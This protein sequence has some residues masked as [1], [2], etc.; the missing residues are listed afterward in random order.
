MNGSSGDAR[1]TRAEE[2]VATAVA[3][4]EAAE[5]RRELPM[6][7]V[8]VVEEE[9]VA[10]LRSEAMA[11]EMVPVGSTETAGCWRQRAPRRRRRWRR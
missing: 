4:A 3:R 11:R 10:A 8:T 1:G 9:T 7:V 5:T 2:Q 6:P